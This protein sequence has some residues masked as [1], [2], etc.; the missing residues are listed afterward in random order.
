MM[1]TK[2]DTLIARV[3][4]ELKEAVD[5]AAQDLSAAASKASA[6][7]GSSPVGGNTPRLSAASA[8]SVLG[9]LHASWAHEMQQ[10]I[11]LLSQLNSSDLTG[12]NDR[13]SSQLNEAQAN[14]EQAVQDAVAAYTSAADMYGRIS[15][16]GAA[17]AMNLKHAVEVRIASLTGQAAP[18]SPEAGAQPEDV[19]AS[20]DRSAPSMSPGA[21]GAESPEA[22]AAA[23]GALTTDAAELEFPRYL[24]PIERV[25]FSSPSARAFAQGIIDLADTLKALDGAMQAAFGTAPGEGIGPVFRTMG[26]DQDQITGATLI[27]AEGDA[28]QISV[29][30]SQSGERTVSASNIDGR[31]YVGTPDDFTGGLMGEDL[32]MQM[33]DPATAAA[34][35]QMFGTMVSTL[36]SFTARVQAGEFSSL[37]EAAAALGEAMMNAMGAMMPQP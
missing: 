37:D 20:D 2:L 5:A 23:I 19:D 36:Q 32:D 33:E 9:Q 25:N 16:S 10:R 11:D 24:M 17:S 26:D 3:N 15:G 7:A 22:L 12:M 27:S 28:A 13:F 14:R 18:T 1:T 34:A 8:H 29:T 21:G 35:G 30:N 31:W 6:A 4:G